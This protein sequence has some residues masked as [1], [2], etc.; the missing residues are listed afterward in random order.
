[1]KK[2]ISYSVWGNNPV[3]VINA[4]VNADLAQDLYPGWI[5]RFYCSPNVPIGIVKEL[6]SRP[7][8]ETVLMNSDEDWNGMFWRFRAASDPEVEVMISRDTDSH[9]DVREKE[10]VDEWLAS[11]K[12]FHIM[13]DQR[14]HGVPILGGMW[15]ARRGIMRDIASMIDGYSRKDSNNRK[16][17]DQEFL[18]SHVFP[19]VQGRS[20]IHDSVEGR[21]GGRTKDFPT[22]RQW[23]WREDTLDDSH[24]NNYIGIIRSVP[25]E[26]WDKYYKLTAL[27]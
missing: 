25:Q 14:H 18:W 22:P 16:N 23:P 20:F 21:C 6:Q 19:M 17:I 10:A 9:L 3:Y 24:D 11:D 12:D 7:N 4:I 26:Y 8:V 15:G 1:M 2:I 27:S 5:C 13:R